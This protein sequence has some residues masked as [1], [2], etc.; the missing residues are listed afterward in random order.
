[1]DIG[2]TTKP[3]ILFKKVKQNKFPLLIYLYMQIYM[4]TYIHISIYLYMYLC[5]EKL[6]Q[7]NEYKNILISNRSYASDHDA[8]GAA[9][10]SSAIDRGPAGDDSW[11]HLFY[12]GDST[13]RF[14]CL[15][16]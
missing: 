9:N 10:L 1:M 7:V 6:T 14:S 15:A 2:K 13:P 11:S 5:V 3:K 4:C 12:I 16:F 8:P